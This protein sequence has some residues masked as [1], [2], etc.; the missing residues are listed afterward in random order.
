MVLQHRYHIIKWAQHCD[1]I[2][3]KHLILVRNTMIL[4]L[5]TIITAFMLHCWTAYN[6]RSRYAKAWLE[7]EF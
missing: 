6:S 5:G 1:M 3:N 4:S 7:E 2:V